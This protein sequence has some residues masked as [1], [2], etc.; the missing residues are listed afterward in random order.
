MYQLLVTFSILALLG[1][2][3]FISEATMGVGVIGFGCGLGILARIAQAG[4]QHKA[5]MARNDVGGDS[6]ESP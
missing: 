5:A 4:A 1:G 6:A 2:F 3:L